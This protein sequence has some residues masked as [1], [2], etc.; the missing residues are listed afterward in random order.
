MRTQGRKAARIPKPVSQERLRS[1]AL[2]YLSR[3]ASSTGNLKRVLA[4]RADKI[5][6]HHETDRVADREAIGEMISAVAVKL[7]AAGLLDDSAYAESRTR[8]LHRGGASRRKIAAYLAQKGVAGSDI[9][10]AFQ[11]LEEETDTGNDLD[12]EAALRYAKRRR[13]GPFRDPKKRSERRDKDLAAL[14]RTGFAID[15]ALKIIDAEDLEELEGATRQ[16][17]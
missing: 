16:H 6:R 17:S 12:L 4:R 5:A 2:W 13:L 14:A 9:A 1:Y 3:Y 8:S 10:A 11:T 7:E 15:I